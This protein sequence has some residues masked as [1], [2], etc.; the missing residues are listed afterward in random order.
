MLKEIKKELR[1]L[2]RYNKISIDSN[3]KTIYIESKEGFK[4][5][6]EMFKGLNYIPNN[7]VELNGIDFIISS[8]FYDGTYKHV[9]LKEYSQFLK[10][11]K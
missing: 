3:K 1:A 4:N 10:D 6:S 9:W 2:H 5:F 7:H 11:G 8:F